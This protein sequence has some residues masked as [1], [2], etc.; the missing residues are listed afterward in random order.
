M[1]RCELAAHFLFAQGHVSVAALFGVM[2]TCKGVSFQSDDSHTHLLVINDSTSTG[3]Y[4]QRFGQCFLLLIFKV[5]K[6][7]TE[8]WLFACVRI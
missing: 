6:G 1:G 7:V 4:R 3:M 2:H 8:R 5:G